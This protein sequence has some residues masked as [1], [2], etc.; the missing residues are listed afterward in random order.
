MQLNLVLWRAR[1]AQALRA[2]D[3]RARHA[4][5]ILMEGGGDIL[6]LELG[7]LIR[8]PNENPN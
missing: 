3:A 5:A 6:I 4:G 1:C 8:I 2:G 7:F